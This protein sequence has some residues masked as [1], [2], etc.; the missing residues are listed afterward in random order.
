M[1]V[2]WKEPGLFRW[3]ETGI[4]D[5]QR[6]GGGRAA[7]AATGR[8]GRAAWA[9]GVH[10]ARLVVRV[11]AA[12]R[13]VQLNCALCDAYVGTCCPAPR[14]PHPMLLYLYM[15]MRAWGAGGG[16]RGGEGLSFLAEVDTTVGALRAVHPP[17]VAGRAE[18]SG[19]R[20]WASLASLALAQ[21]VFL[22]L[23]PSLSLSPSPSLSLSLGVP[24]I[25]SY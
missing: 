6:D 21:S 1:C 5:E 16:R 4:S 8:R 20:V 22:S 17:G 14:S 11:R 25:I 10:T 24:R 2:R 23:P 18:A 12:H 9:R 13:D 19:W 7:G 3:K 15:Y